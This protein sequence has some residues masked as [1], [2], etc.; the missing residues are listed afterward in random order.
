MAFCPA[1]AFSPFLRL[2]RS[3]ALPAML[4]SALLAALAPSA[5]AGCGSNEEPRRGGLGESCERTDD[6]EAP[7][8][9]VEHVC[10]DPNAVDAGD[11]GDS[12]PPFEAGPSADAGPW[13]PCDECLDDECA[14]ELAACDGECQ[15]IEA[16]IE[17]LCTNLSAIGSADEGACQKYCQDKHP[18]AKDKHL[19]V[20]DCALSMVCNPP[21]T[22]YPDD[23]DKCTL[24]MNQGD[25]HAQ[26]EACNASNDC[27]TY[28]DCVLL[29][30][31][32]KDCL[33]C[34]DTPEGAAG[35]QIYDAYEQCI[36]RECVSES[37]L[38]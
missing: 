23:Y 5:F 21:C 34:D 25:C 38:P 11:A 8:S 4:V 27:Q 37:W 16:C 9:C 17:T 20:V 31:T 15:A 22:L 24:F 1:M 19:A 32:L 35:H 7:Y 13:G 18:G 36:A 26:R 2:R 10:S 3:R 12:G 30:G 28:K 14:A 33:A 29:C 6:C